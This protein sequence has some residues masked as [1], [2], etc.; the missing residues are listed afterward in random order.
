MAQPENL[1]YSKEHEWVKIDDDTATIGITDY[2][3][4]SLGD[5]VYVELPKVGD[6]VA[7]FSNA[8]VIE[9]VKAVSDLYSPISGE[10]VEINRELD[11]NPAA[12]NQAPYA[13]GWLFKVRVSDPSETANLLSAAD[14]EK[15]AAI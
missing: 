15:L 3:Q 2:A 11:A 1:L 7:Q 14:Y 6:K 8:G 9:S 4:N 10:I 5:I 12:V 13:A